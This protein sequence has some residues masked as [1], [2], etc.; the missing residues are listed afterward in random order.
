MY[1]TMYDTGY[2]KIYH[3]YH[4]NNNIIIMINDKVIEVA[5]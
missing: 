3:D 2:A 4:D 1:P 5:L